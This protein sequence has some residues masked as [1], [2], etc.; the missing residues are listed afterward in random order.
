MDQ[1]VSANQFPSPQAAGALAEI[2]PSLTS[3]M[4]LIRHRSVSDVSDAMPCRA[5]AWV[6]SL[7]GFYRSLGAD[8]LGGR[9]VADG[10]SDTD[11]VSR[12]SSKYQVAA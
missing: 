3:R 8:T 10:Q 12:R 6:D 5:D 4:R 9:T 11:G 2:S 7:G 1:V